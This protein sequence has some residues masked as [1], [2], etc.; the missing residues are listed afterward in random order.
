M[1]RN[2]INDADAL[3]RQA[4]LT[5]SEYGEYPLIPKGDLSVEF[6]EKVFDFNPLLV[7]DKLKTVLMSDLMETTGHIYSEEQLQH[8]VNEAYSRQEVY[9]KKRILNI[10]IKNYKRDSQHFRI[11]HHS[12][13]TL[14][15]EETVIFYY[16]F[17]IFYIA[18]ALRDGE[19]LLF[20]R[21]VLKIIGILRCETG[22]SPFDGIRHSGKM[23]SIYTFQRDRVIY[24][25]LI[26]LIELEIET[27]ADDDT[28]RKL[29]RIRSRENGTNGCY[30]ATCVYGSYNCPQ[31]WLLRRFRD[32]ALS[33]NV[34]GRAFI[35]IYY[36]LSP[37]A[38]KILG[39]YGW[40]VKICRP[41][42]DKLVSRLMQKGYTNSPYS[43]D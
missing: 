7:L 1:D 8:I 43:N 22:N 23:L 29:N 4:N 27:A 36:A 32:N 30:I 37:T 2:N 28:K 11:R 13:M 26:S 14:R 9:H 16:A 3:L 21:E 40:F 15:P 12:Y 19:A 42:L 6:I 5:A 35:K 33:S 25:R 38:V 31:V 41:P 20:A 24:Y 39:K 18:K 17:S 34:F 10:L